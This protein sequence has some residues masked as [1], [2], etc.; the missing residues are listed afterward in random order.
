LT[1]TT[2]RPLPPSP[3]EATRFMERQ[4][5]SG[6]RAIQSEAR[7]SGT[8]HFYMHMKRV[9]ADMARIANTLTDTTNG[10]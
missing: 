9:D 10:I 8:Q 7:D 5:T 3:G 4:E 6:S 2:A 1:S